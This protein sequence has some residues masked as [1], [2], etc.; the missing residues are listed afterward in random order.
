MPPRTDPRPSLLAASPPAAEGTPPEEP[1]ARFAAVMAHDLNNIVAVIAG[2][3]ALLGK[4]VAPAGSAGG[5]VRQVARAGESAKSLVRRIQAFTGTDTGERRDIDLKTVVHEALELM[6]PSLPPSIRLSSSE[7]AEPLTIHAD[8]AQLAYLLRNLCL[9]ARDAI[10][11]Q[12]G[13]VILDVSLLRAGTNA[14]DAP[15]L[16]PDRQRRQRVVLGRPAPG[17]LARVAVIDSGSGME[18]AIMGRMFEPFFTTKKPDLGA[19]LGLAAVGAIVRAHGGAVIVDSEPGAGTSVT[20]V[21]PASSS[22]APSPS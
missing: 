7:I 11:G 8:R 22:Q 10:G 12:R 4:E 21:L 1:L 9:N 13:Q 15:L 19:G 2:Y 16:P 20:V 6:R 14:G 17:P 5:Y 3:A 18:P